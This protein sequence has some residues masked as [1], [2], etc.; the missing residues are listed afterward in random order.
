MT[1]EPMGQQSSHSKNDDSEGDKE[2]EAEKGFTLSDKPNSKMSNSKDEEEDNN[3]DKD[4]GGDNEED[5]RTENTVNAPPMTG[6]QEI[7]QHQNAEV[8][9][10]QEDYGKGRPKEATE[11]EEDIHKTNPVNEKQENDSNE[12]TVEKKSSVGY[13]KTRSRIL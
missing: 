1:E 8:N 3:N 9:D 5:D 4:N 11:V 2:K 6:D 7:V 13:K 12:H 10:P